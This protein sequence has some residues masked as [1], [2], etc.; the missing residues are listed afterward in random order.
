M[1][2]PMLGILAVSGK[3]SLVVDAVSRNTEEFYIE[4]NL[5]F[6]DHALNDQRPKW[7]IITQSQKTFENSASLYPSQSGRR[8]L[9]YSD[10]GDLLVTR[11]CTTM[12]H[13]ALSRALA[14]KRSFPP[15]SGGDYS[16]AH[17]S[18]LF[19]SLPSPSPIPSPKYEFSRLCPPI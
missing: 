3:L 7:S 15:E 4:T 6:G 10:C 1:T 13:I 19:F 17:H 8:S 12:W 5:W 14:H 16:S 18:S 9:R 2:L 11:F